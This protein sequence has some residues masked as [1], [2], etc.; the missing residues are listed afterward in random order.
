MRRVNQLYALYRNNDGTIPALKSPGRPRGEITE[1]ERTVVRDALRRFGVGACYLEHLIR[2]FYGIKIHHMKVYRVMKEEGL[3]YSR[4]R[5]H[6]RRRWIRYE[7]EHSNELWHTDWHEMEHPSYRGK[8]LLVYE[9]DASRFII[10][11]RLF[12][13]ESSENAVSVLDETIREYG[14]P[15]QVLSDRGPS[16]CANESEARRKGLTKFEL[17]L[18]SHHIE[19]VL[20][21]VRHPETN[22]KLEKLFDTLETGLE[23]GF[24]PIERCVEWHNSIKPHGS[25]DLESCETPVQA[26]YRKMRERDRLVDPSIVIQG[27]GK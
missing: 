5:R 11:W 7:R 8:Q 1:E 20:C 16:F 27:G 22:G 18:M 19:Q 12:D 4:A 25:L 3:L 15:D 2:N 14:R 10:G 6:V 17:Y 13:S 9:D 24:F 21:G 23:R 26:Y